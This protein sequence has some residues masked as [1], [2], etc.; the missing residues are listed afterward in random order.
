MKQDDLVLIQGTGGVA[1]FAL[2]LVKAFGARAAIISSSDEK[3]AKAKQLGADITINYKEVPDWDAELFQLTDGHGADVV[4]ELGGKDTLER[5]LRAVAPHGLIS[6]VGVLT[7]WAHAPE[8]ISDLV[9]KNA[10]LAGVL[11]GSR[12]Y[13][14]NLSALSPNTRSSH[15]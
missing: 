2:Q 10:S 1:I 9:L 14:E 6:Q 11:V 15:W 4:L 7:G 12:T 5:S 13:F 8:N 3:L